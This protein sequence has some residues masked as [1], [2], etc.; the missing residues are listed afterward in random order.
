MR[1]DTVHLYANTQCTLKCG[2]CF[3][4]LFKEGSKNRFLKVA[5]KVADCSAERV[6]IGG[7]E[8]TLSPALL[9]VMKILKDG[10]KY[11]ELHTNATTL[12]PKRLDSYEGIVDGIAIPIDTLN[13]TS[14]MFLKGIDYVP[15]FERVVG[16][17]KKYDFEV[18]YHTVATK[19]NMWSIPDMY[20][21]LDQTKFKQWKIY[22]FD[23]ALAIETTE[24]MDLKEDEIKRRE[25]NFCCMYGAPTRREAGGSDSL[26]AEHLLCEE[27]MRKQHG[28]DKRVF[29]GELI[30]ISNP[31]L[32]VTSNG[33][34]LFSKYRIKMG[35]KRNIGNVMKRDL[36]G[37][38]RGVSEKVWKE[39]TK[40]FIEDMN[41]R[42]LFARVVED[43]YNYT[44]VEWIT[45][46]HWP[47]VL[48]LMDLYRKR[49][50]YPKGRGY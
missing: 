15:I 35:N 10:G 18:T 30:D 39:Y 23:T 33:D 48:H 27:K 13:R 2:Y 11:V 36:D 26:L 24:A 4:E 19:P 32:F 16:D 37:I 1:S 22:E 28:R 29:F 5:E 47:K 17:L 46:E 14:Q 3:R 43:I 38:V 9:D 7:A 49:K 6:I 42:P 21:I 25:N 31:Y 41:R 45:E 40:H 20:P 50:G 44:E 8:P 12:T 34:V